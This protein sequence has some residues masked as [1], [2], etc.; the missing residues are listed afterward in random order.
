VSGTVTSLTLTNA[1]TGYTAMPS[2]VFSGGGTP[3]TPAS[4]TVAAPV[5]QFAPKAIQEL[6]T[7]DYGRMNA[8]FG[9]ELPFT[10]FFTQTT[11]PYGYVDPPT[12][13][14]KEGDTFFW[15]ITHNGVDTHFIHFHLFDVQVVNRIGWDGMIKPPDANEIAWKDTVRMNPLEDVVIALRPMHQ[16]LPWELPNSV[17]PLDVTM[18][19]GVSNPANTFG[20]ANIDTGNNPVTVTNDVTNFGAE[21]VWHCHI[22]SHEEIDMMRPMIKAIPPDAPSNVIATRV[23]SGN[24][25]QVVLTWTDNSINE[26]GFTVQRATSL[27]GPWLSLT[28]GAPAIPGIG[29]TVTYTDNTVARRTSY[30][31]QVIANNLVGYTQQYAAPAV[32]YPTY[33]ADSVPVAAAAP[34]TILSGASDI[35]PIFADSFEK[36]IAA[37]NGLA[38]DLTRGLLS[39]GAPQVVG[40]LEVASKASIGSDGGAYGLAAVVDGVKQQG[41]YVFSI[42]PGAESMYDANFYFNANDV[43]SDASPIDIFIGLDQ[44]GQP[45]FGVQYQTESALTYKLRAWVM[46]DGLPAYT[47]WDIFTVDEL[48]DAS[49]K[50]HKIDLAWTSGSMAGLSLYIDDVHFATLMGDTSRYQLGEVLLGP[51][52][53]LS[54]GAS[55]TMYFD[56]FTSSRVNGIQGGTIL[57][58]PVITQ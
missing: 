32:G 13:I 11:I 37:W 26:S 33:S 1:G 6:F 22:L 57:F 2:V 49:A 54:S 17:R 20:F 14:V 21:Y 28:P 24:S 43:V 15:K 30:Y 23:G 16:T 39:N 50:T 47:P 48:E 12:E 42:L 56:A 52:L 36:G 5:T 29:S 58:L 3:A 18:P 38:G 4:A 55:G 40:S 46:Q 35:L 44:N 51:S 34:V 25:Q 53:G 27:S 7:L 41:T 45:A 19:I 8:T 31:Y 10:N 9:V